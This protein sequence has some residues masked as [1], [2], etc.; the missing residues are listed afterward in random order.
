M[1]DQVQL[2]SLALSKGPNRVGAFLPSPEDGDRSSFG[3]VVF[4]N[5]LI[6]DDGQS[7]ETRWF[8]LCSLLKFTD[9]LEENIVSI[10]R[11]KE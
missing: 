7:P 6:P 9:I 5:Y 3:N 1:K 11:V 4:F 8:W 2:L 10:F